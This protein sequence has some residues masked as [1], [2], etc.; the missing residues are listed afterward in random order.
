[1]PD[2]RELISEVPVTLQN[3]HY[4]VAEPLPYLA[5]VVNVACLHCRP[6]M[7][8]SPDLELF[9][10]G[11]MKIKIKYIIFFFFFFYNSLFLHKLSNV[12]IYYLTLLSQLTSTTTHVYYD[13]FKLKKNRQEDI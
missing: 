8:L 3:S 11:G 7:A 2:V 5:N 1:M 12:P 4:S 9:L 6:P 13:N 10:R